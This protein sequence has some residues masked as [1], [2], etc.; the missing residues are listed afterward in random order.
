MTPGIPILEKIPV[1]EIGLKIQALLPARRHSDILNRLDASLLLFDKTLVDTATGATIEIEVNEELSWPEALARAARQLLSGKDDKQVMLLLPTV[2]F[3]ATA[4]SMNMPGEKLVRSAL[5]LQ[6]QS[7]IPAY[8]EKLLLAVDAAHTDGVALWFNENEANR[9]FRAFSHEGLFLGAIMPRSLALLD[10]PQDGGEQ[11][12]LLINDEEG[13]NI[14]FMQVKG[15]SIRRLLTVNKLDLEQD[16][17]AKQWDIETSQLKGDAVCNMTTMDDWKAIKRKVE[18]VPEYC[19]LPA[20]AIAEEKRIDFVRKS[21]AA[22][23]V[24]ACLVLLLFAPFIARWLELRELRED[25]ET[26]LSQ[27]EEPRRLQAS[28]FDMEQEWGAL[29]EYPDQQVAN[30]LVSLN[31]VT[32]RSLTSFSIN[33][34]VIDITGATDDPAYLVAL[35]AEREE[36]NN[37]GQSTSTR[38]AGSQFGIRLNLSSVDFAEYEEKYPVKTQGR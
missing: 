5:E 32:Q 29:Y 23:A 6:S 13:G 28:I 31:E 22:M 38:G 3:I 12:T 1:R 33:K 27:S 11:R 34:G 16:V 25:L 7:L 37:V 26:A 21:K 19:F 30:V 24:A 9:L 20:G 14:S 17:F 8:D 15:T 4:Y 10:K 18:P 35:L 36:F 2:D